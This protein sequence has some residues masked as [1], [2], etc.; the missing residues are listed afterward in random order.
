MQLKSLVSTCKA[1]NVQEGEV[2][3]LCL[4]RA[5]NHEDVVITAGKVLG[6]VRLPKEIPDMVFLV[7]CNCS[8]DMFIL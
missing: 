8:R 4:V 5:I 1:Y 6:Q 2:I 3:G 7:H